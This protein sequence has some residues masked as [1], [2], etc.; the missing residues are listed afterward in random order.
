[1]EDTPDYEA[2][3]AIARISGPTHLRSNPPVSLHGP[4]RWQYSPKSDLQACGVL[5]WYMRYQL[6]PSLLNMDRGKRG[7]VSLVD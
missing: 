2:T 1:M 7:A 6:Y 4:E 5:P 3:S